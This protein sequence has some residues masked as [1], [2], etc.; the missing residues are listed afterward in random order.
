MTVYP[1]SEVEFIGWIDANFPYGRANVWPAVIKLGVSISS[2]AAFAVLDEICRPPHS[3]KPSLELRLSML[4][5]W[6]QHFDHP[7]K[8]L[9]LPAARAL[10]HDVCIPVDDAIAAMK[11]IAVWPGEYCALSIPYFACDDVEGHADKVH[12]DIRK[13]WQKRAGDEAV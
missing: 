3:Y 13:S 4:A 10:V 9:V 12:E 6:D 7:L 2:N 8:S 5:Y 11:E 1:I